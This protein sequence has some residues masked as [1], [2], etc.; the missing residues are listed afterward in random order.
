MYTSWF[1]NCTAH[2]CWVPCERDWGIKTH[3]G[4]LTEWCLKLAHIY[5]PSPMCEQHGTCPWVKV[6]AGVM[7]LR[8]LKQ[9]YWG[10]VGIQECL[11]ASMCP[12]GFSCEQTSIKMLYYKTENIYC[13]PKFLS[14]CP[15]VIM[16]VFMGHKYWQSLCFLNQFTWP[17]FWPL[18][19][20][21]KLSNGS[22]PSLLLVF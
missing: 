16:W 1:H 20:W 2:H 12:T 21:P 15:H 5:D 4:T 10:T 6:G 19:V 3:K 18:K 14:I 7:S 17:F 22:R 13:F 9:I 11:L 8:L